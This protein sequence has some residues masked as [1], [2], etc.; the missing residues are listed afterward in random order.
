MLFCRD[1]NVFLVL[2]LRILHRLCTKTTFA[3]VEIILAGI[4]NALLV[5][6]NRLRVYIRHFGSCVC[7]SLTYL[8]FRPSIRSA[9]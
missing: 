2:L 7:V 5:E 3:P 4:V 9:A 1:A 6:M 8:V